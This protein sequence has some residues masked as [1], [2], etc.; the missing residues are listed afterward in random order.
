[1]SRFHVYFIDIL[2]DLSCMDYELQV[3]PLPKSGL[4]ELV[5]PV[6][7]VTMK[8]PQ[9]QSLLTAVE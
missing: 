6:K 5:S 3:T 4:N 2:T 8:V 7:K 9:V 1:M